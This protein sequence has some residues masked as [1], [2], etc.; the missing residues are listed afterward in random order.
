MSSASYRFHFK[1]EGIGRASIYLEDY[2][3]KQGEITIGCFG[4]AWNHFFSNMGTGRQI[5]DFLLSCSDDYL[6][7]KLSSDYNR[8]RPIDE[9]KICEYIRREVLRVRRQ[10]LLDKEVAR[11]LWQLAGHR[12]SYEWYNSAEFNILFPCVTDF[13]PPRKTDFLREY[14]EEIVPAMKDYLRSNWWAV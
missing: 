4:E 11:E 10:C 2:G 7:G 14:L 8:D 3:N 6:I 1:V 12:L 9:N 13:D 5:K